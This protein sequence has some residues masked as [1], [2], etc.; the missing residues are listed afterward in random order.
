MNRNPIPSTLFM[1]FFAFCLFFSHAVLFAQTDSVVVIFGDTRTKISGNTHT[2]NTINKSVINKLMQFK[3]LAV[4]HTGDIVFNGL[5]KSAWIRFEEFCSPI[6]NGSKFYPAYGNHEL[7]SK[8][9]SRDFKLPNNGKWYS[10]DVMN[11]HFV[12]IDNF[13]DYKTGS[14][15][16]RWIENDLKNCNKDK[17]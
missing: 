14:E 1:I 3:P 11:I 4:F 17:F 16:Y 15:Q 10:V 5:K 6:I 13:S 9:V 7:H 2:N 8:T 12:I